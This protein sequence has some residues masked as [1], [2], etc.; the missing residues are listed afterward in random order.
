MGRTSLMMVMGFSAI[1][2]F[3]G[4]NMTH[5]SNEAVKNFVIYRA[6]TQAHNIASSAANVAC[7]KIF[8]TPNWR[9][10]YNNVPFAGGRYFVQVRDLAERRIQVTARATYSGPN[11]TTGL[12]EEKQS[13]ITVVMQPSS[14][15]KFAY[16]SEVEGGISWITGDTV[17][18][19]FHSEQKITVSGSPVFYGKVT[20]RMGLH[21]SPASSKPEF[22][23]G[24]QSGV[25]IKLPNDMNPMEEAAA[26]GG[27]CVTGKDL[28]LEF[29]ADGTVT[30]QEG[31][32]PPQTTLLSS[33]A[34]NGIIC[35]DGGNMRVK[36]V[37]HGHVTL[38]ALGS[39]GAGKGNVFIDDDLVYS[40][41]PQDPEC[42]DLLGIA[43]DNNV[44][45]T[46]NAANNNNINIHATIFCRTGGFGAE[47]YNTRPVAGSIN[48]TGGIQQYQRN[49]VGTYSGSTV[50]HGFLKNYRYDERMMTDLPP[51]YPTTGSY[52]IVSWYE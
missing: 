14:F 36:G 15:S 30:Y 50:N 10:G 47:N 6:K 49:A 33:Y 29:H 43:V 24:Y 31:G 52:E 8:F 51:F 11:D 18:G 44:W 35:V 1:F 27:H 7:N 17:W 41:N 37:V 25:S 2:A 22:Y 40:K 46:D 28:T 32:D 9:E 26:D 19:P 42:S 38:S 20:S 45:V 13:I 23:G 34:P 4:F 12:Y 3:M 21:K 5:I 48:L 39:S 16:Y